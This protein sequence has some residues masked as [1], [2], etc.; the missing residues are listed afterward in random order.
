MWVVLNFNVNAKHNSH[1][2]IE[3]EKKVAHS[4]VELCDYG[5]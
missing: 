1:D 2:L 4:L 5:I 3:I